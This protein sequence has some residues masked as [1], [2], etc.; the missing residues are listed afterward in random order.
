MNHSL[1][2]HR[3]SRHRQRGLSA[4]SVVLIVIV[5]AQVFMLGMKL[6]TPVNEYMTLRHTIQS[7]KNNGPVNALEVRQ[8]FENQQK[9]EYSIKSIGAKDL[10]VEVNGAVT[11]I[12]FAYDKEIQLFGPVYLLIKFQARTR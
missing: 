8:A 4:I 7:I 1:L 3:A 12:S 6:F 9:I 11:A 10:Q 5:L 2:R